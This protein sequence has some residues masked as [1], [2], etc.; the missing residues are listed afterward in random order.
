MSF[1]FLFFFFSISAKGSFSPAR[2][3]LTISAVS[4]FT[5][6]SRLTRSIARQAAPSVIL[7]ASLIA[8]HTGYSVKPT[9]PNSIRSS[10]NWENY[11]VGGGVATSDREVSVARASIATRWNEEEQFESIL[12]REEALTSA[13][14]KVSNNLFAYPRFVCAQ[15]QLNQRNLY[16]KKKK[17]T[18]GDFFLE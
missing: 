16:L 7:P 2:K 14:I 9:A 17:K 11:W 18:D 10:S 8:L 15:Q 1:F 3:E 4:I 6:N 12:E 13:A 5:Q